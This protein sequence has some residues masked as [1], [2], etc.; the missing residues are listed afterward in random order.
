[1]RRLQDTFRTDRAT[2]SRTMFRGWLTYGGF[3]I[4]RTC[5]T[6]KSSLF[7][8]LGHNRAMEAAEG[9]QARRPPLLRNNH[10]DEFLMVNEGIFPS[11]FSMV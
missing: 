4:C 8:D 7:A 2:G 3:G 10:R 5:L 9:L 11:V 6:A 1:M